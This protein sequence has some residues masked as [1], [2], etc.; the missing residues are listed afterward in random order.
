MSKIF[1][2]F[3]F[4]FVSLSYSQTNKNTIGKVTSQS[5]RILEDHSGKILTDSIQRKIFLDKKELEAEIN[6][7]KLK[8]RLAN[9]VHLCSN[10][11]FEEFEV[12]SGSN[13]LKDFSYTTENPLNPTQCS[14]P[15]VTANNTI[16][17]YN[18]SQTSLM[19]ST[20]PSNFIDD[21][22]G[23]INAFDQYALKI[24]FKNSYSTSGIVQA[25]RFKTNNEN[26]IIL[27]YKVVL[28]TI[29]GP[30]HQNEQPFFKVRI[31]R[32]NG[33]IADEFCLIGDP[34]NC[35]FTQAPSYEAGSIV[36]FTPNWQTG[37]LN[38]SSIPNNEEFTIE[39]TAARC[40][41][42]GHF[43]YAYIDDMCL[44]HSDENLQGSIELNPLFQICPTLP[45][46][47]CGTFTIPNS[48]GVAANVNGITLNV[49]NNNN[50]IIYTSSTPTN[51]NLTNNTFCFELT[52][53]NLPNITTGNYNVSATINYNINQTNCSGTTFN[54]AT[55]P[56]ANIGWDISFLN[57]TTDCNFPIQTGTLKMCDTN[58][59]GKD[60]FDLTLVKNQIIGIQTGL[61]LSYFSTLPD[62]TNNTNPITIPTS[63]ESYT[64]TLYVR[65]TKDANCYKII[66]FQ[67]VVKNPYASISGIL[68]VCSGSTNLSANSGVSYLW[69]TGE[70]TQTISVSATGTYSVTVIDTDGCAASG[71]VTIIPSQVAVSPTLEITQPTCFIGTGTIEITSPAAE[72]SFDGGV[73]WTTNN[74]SS[75]LNTGTYLVQ[76]R[77]INN[78]YS[79]N[80]TVNILPFL[81]DYPFYSSTQPTNCNSLGSITITTAASEYSFDNGLTWSTNN[82]ATN[83]PIGTYQIRTKDANGCISN[84]NSVVFQAEFLSNP[85]YQFSPPYCSNLGSIIFTSQSDFYSIDGG[86]TWQTAATFDNLTS[87]SYLLKIKNSLGC[88]SP[89]TYVY[90]TS[91]ENTYPNYTI[92][93]AGCNTYAS[94][95]INT[96]GDEY[97]F[98]NGLTWS[99]SN[100]LTNLIGGGLTYQLNVK[101]GINCY[102]LTSYATVYSSFLPLPS[103]FNY[104]TLICDN[105]NNSNELVNL[106]LYNS[107][108]VANSA[109]HTFNYYNTYNGALNQ[110]NS[111]KI[112]SP[113][114]YNL[115]TPNKIIYVT[116]K[117]INGC[118]NISELD[119]T[120]IQTPIPTIADKFYLCENYSVLLSE[121][122]YFDSYL[123]STGET[124]QSIIVNQTGNY[125]LTVTQNHGA[126]ICST[127][128]N[129]SVVLSNPA[130]ILTI[131]TEDWTD[132]NNIMSVLLTNSSI[133]NYVYSLD[134]IN[135]QTSNVFLGLESGEYDVFIKD[136]NGCGIIKDDFYLLMYPKFFTPNGDGFNDFWKVRLSQ[137]EPNFKIAIFDRYGKLLKTM[138]S[139]ESWDGKLNGKDLPS[140]DYWFLV[141]RQNG[142][143]FR[144]HFAMKR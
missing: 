139:F 92:N 95:V 96:I 138:N 17:Q 42:G 19:S 107:Y 46:N 39:M 22:I 38:I 41:L 69:S 63:F 8:F 86:T 1:L 119:L 132:N 33:T 28:Q 106:T 55:D 93:N 21:F 16:P 75:N 103:V 82:T 52:A 84:F 133:G 6:A 87:G 97:S 68:N 18:P 122:Q 89:T 131:N 98:D 78:C 120:L 67:V 34:T 88:T 26:Q 127:T 91:L 128:K 142:K 2:I 56:D 126:I 108:F 58:S 48:G 10:S 130:K 99:T 30:E 20:V 4:L 27:N 57:C 102:S 70:T 141:T 59:D 134:G 124:T 66:A 111:D 143:E 44:A 47:V 135:Y 62:A 7:P 49:Y 90:L 105:Q 64:S 5:E 115:N 77:T 101:K 137:K 31:I 45:I 136:V 73:T 121:S 14:T 36:L 118:A 116:V 112:Q 54:S 85:T 60:I 65:I 129:I 11:N 12:I 51:L 29:E 24:N 76:I 83:L 53:A 100:I 113:T 50:A 144:G 125:S 32:S 94:I 81:S 61:T 79:Y 110:L 23:N 117:D 72:Y 123:W 40:G 71:S 104:A 25:K 15:M 114:N 37:T 109:N 13:Y 140:T 3:S 80:T 35:I 9:P 43:G 74:S